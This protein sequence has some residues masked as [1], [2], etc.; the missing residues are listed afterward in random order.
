MFLCR[1]CLAQSV[2]GHSHLLSI[3]HSKALNLWKFYYNLRNLGGSP[4][5]STIFYTKL[6]W[7]LANY[8]NENWKLINKLKNKQ[9]HAVEKYKHELAHD[10]YMS[11]SKILEHSLLKSVVWLN[12]PS[13]ICDGQDQKSMIIK[14]CWQTDNNWWLGSEEFRWV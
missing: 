6:D 8:L 9:M 2:S 13:I 12:K 7:K 4:A 3:Y 14:L 10:T 11:H 1:N 5:I